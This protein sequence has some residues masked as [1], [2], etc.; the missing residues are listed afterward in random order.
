VKDKKLGNKKLRPFFSMV[1]RRKNLH[2]EILEQATELL[3]TPMNAAVPYAS[4][5]ERMGEEGQPLELL[6]PNSPAAV[7]FRKLWVSV[8]KDLWAR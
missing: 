7:E 1:D 8:R 3:G 4:V 6:A 5:V 2:R